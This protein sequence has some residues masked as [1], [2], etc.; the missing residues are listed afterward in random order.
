MEP[1]SVA[2]ERLVDQ[3]YDHQHQAGGG[4][5]APGMGVPLLEPQRNRFA[6]LKG[7]LHDRVGLCERDWAAGSSGQPAAGRLY[8]TRACLHAHHVHIIAGHCS[9]GLVSQPGEQSGCTVLQAEQQQPK[10]HYQAQDV[11]RLLLLP[12]PSA[13]SS[14]LVWFLGCQHGSPVRRLMLVPAC[15][16]G[17]RGRREMKRGLW[18]LDRLCPLMTTLRVRCS[19]C[20]ASYM[21][22]SVVRVAGQVMNS[23]KHSA[24]I[25]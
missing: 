2:G 21:S 25:V 14:V 10:A 5:A 12:E 7:H 9:A 24:S 4:I 11:Q 19:I 1:C 6:G 15:H 16:Y 17:S 18:M 13:W 20:L 22:I 23:G 8:S 3:A